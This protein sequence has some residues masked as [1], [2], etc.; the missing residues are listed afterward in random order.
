ML[1]IGLILPKRQTTARIYRYYVKH[2]HASCSREV[3]RYCS[4]T[5]K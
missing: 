4:N 5:I 2:T 1:F 3:C